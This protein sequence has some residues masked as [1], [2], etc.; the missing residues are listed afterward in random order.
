MTLNEFLQ[1]KTLSAVDLIDFDYNQVINV[2]VRIFQN[3]VQ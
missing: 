3:I 2:Y 1:D